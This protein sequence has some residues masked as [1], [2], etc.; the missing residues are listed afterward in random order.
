MREQSLE[1]HR[2]AR[3][4][5]PPLAMPDALPIPLRHVS[6]RSSGARDVETNSGSICATGN[7]KRVR[8]E[9]RPTRS[10]W[11]TIPNISSKGIASIGK[12]SLPNTGSGWQRIERQRGSLHG[13]GEPVTNHIGLPTFGSAAELIYR[14]A[15]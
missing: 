8:K 4:V 9:Q 10:G 13:S 7:A 1:S 15:S 6:M 3:P 2:L 5:G 11:L 12:A 14:N